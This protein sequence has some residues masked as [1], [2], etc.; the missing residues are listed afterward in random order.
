MDNYGS[1]SKL[2]DDTVSG[3]ILSEEE[4]TMTTEV[5]YAKRGAISL[6]TFADTTKVRVEERGGT[7]SLSLSDE[8]GKY[9]S[10]GF[11]ETDDE[12]NEFSEVGVVIKW[13]NEEA[14]ICTK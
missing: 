5:I 8:W 9:Y 4:F 12:I 13:I 3:R 2:Y 1:R 7:F 11:I 14:G 6:K 10:S